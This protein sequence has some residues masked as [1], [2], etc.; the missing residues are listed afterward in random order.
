M[1]T[2]APIFFVVASLVAAVAWA[3]PTDDFIR[4]QMKQQNIPGIAVAVVK[5][6]KIVKAQGYGVAD[7]RTKT[8]VSP[9][10]VFKIASVSKQFIATGIMLLV[11][12]GRLA[13]GDP[14][15]KYIQDVPAAWNGITIRHLMTHTA[16]L[17]REPP[18]FDPNSMQ[19]L[20]ELI[21]SAYAV[22]LRFTP[23]ER[24]ETRISDTTFSLR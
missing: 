6:G 11:Q 9:E 13:V 17:V 12:D 3:D 19:P 24:W 14:I 1:K 10:T 18:A 16:G 4:A 20:A 7:L 8:A 21:R 15:A 2:R 23:G 22:P 5:D